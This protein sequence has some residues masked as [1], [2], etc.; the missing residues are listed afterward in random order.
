M[1]LIANKLVIPFTKEFTIFNPRK[2]V[3][4]TSVVTSSLP[5]IESSFAPHILSLV[6][7]TRPCYLWLSPEK[8]GAV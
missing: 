3:G 6:P 4:H 2:S 7:R 1:A 5:V 8:L